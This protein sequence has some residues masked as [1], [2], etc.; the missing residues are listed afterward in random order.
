MQPHEL[1]TLPTGERVISELVPIQKPKETDRTLGTSSLM[2]RSP[3]GS[4]E[5]SWGCI[6]RS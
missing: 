2:T 3:V 5:S 1:S 4:V 6:G